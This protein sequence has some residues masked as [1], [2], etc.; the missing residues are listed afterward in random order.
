LLKW[1]GVR[2]HSTDESTTLMSLL[3]RFQAEEPPPPPP[4]LILRS[5]MGLGL[6]LFL[7]LF[8]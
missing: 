3:L 4:T 8:L 1:L 5:L 6:T 7:A 2:S